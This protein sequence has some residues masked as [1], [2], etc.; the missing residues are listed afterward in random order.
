MPVLQA[1]APTFSHDIAP[2]VRQFC[3]PC[4][5]AGGVGPFPLLRYE[6][7]KKR[8]AQIVAVTRNRYMPPWLLEP[9]HGDF[10]DER[11][12]SDEQIRQIADWAA[13]GEPEGPPDETSSPAQ[14]ADGW[15]LGQ[16]DLVLDAADPAVSPASG[17]DVFW[18]FVFTPGLTA[19]RYVR[20]V[21]IRPGNRGIVHHANLLIDRAG[22]AQRA[23]ATGSSG[24]P[25]MDLTIVR[26]PFDPDGHFLFWKPGAAPHV[27]PDGFAWRL[28]PGDRLVLNTHLHPSGKP[29]AVRPSI[30]VYFS[31]KPPSHF[32][33]LVQMEHDGAIRIPAG[34][35]DFVVSDDFRLP[36][37]VDVLAVYPHAHYL[38]KLL[39]AFATLPDGSRKWLVRIPN[40]DLNWQ[41]V[42][43]Y[44][45][46]L[47]LPK[48]AVISMRY[49]YDN[50]AGNIRNPHQPPRTVRS[51][52]QS[53][54]EMGH[55]W[56]ELL[57]RG[58]AD[59]R[60]ELQE[61]VMRHRLE[62]YPDDFTAN[63]NLG[64]LA[65]ARLN[66]SGAVA[67]LENAVRLDPGRPDAHNMLGA[68]L[69]RVGRVSEAIEELR[70]ALRERP[71]YANARLNLA[72]A[73]LRAGKLDEA[74]DDY[75]QVLA[76]APN[77][78][79]VRAAVETRAR[80][81]EAEG[82]A[83]EAAA[84]YHELNAVPQRD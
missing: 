43:Y 24:F 28:N 27:E 4:H 53:T 55:L 22:A 77:D 19:A 59:R 78:M 75:R 50:S 57:P 49:H 56:L 47:S 44:R 40:W 7:V 21:E 32:P 14:F 70:L 71:D 11:R 16:P 26:S 42:Y 76:A 35:G 73:L 1:A 83:N 54:D 79:T 48:G 23:A 6:E 15:Q 66:V 37:D 45:E 58:A 72:N 46:P 25:G 13:A 52:N 18:N 61:A 9:G 68:A 64:A 60:L 17:P 36:M 41:S 84:L 20:A 5:H 33:L 38:G 39:E 31:D 69:A 34:A 65:M 8:A 29:E 30:G 80:Q 12:L 62:K 51:G 67:M 63:F 2:I 74:V 81:L 3:A 82:K 10:A